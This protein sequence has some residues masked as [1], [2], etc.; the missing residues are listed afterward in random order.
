MQRTRETASEL[1]QRRL[2]CEARLRFRAS[3]EPASTLFSAQT[4]KPASSAQFDTITSCNFRTPVLRFAAGGTKSVGGSAAA[5]SAVIA[6]DGNSRSRSFVHVHEIALG[7][8]SAV[9]DGGAHQ[10]GLLLDRGGRPEPGRILDPDPG[11]PLFPRCQEQRFWV[12]RNTRRLRS[13]ARSLRALRDVGVD[14]PSDDE[15][16]QS[17]ER[18]RPGPRRHSVALGT[19]AEQRADR[20]G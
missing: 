14:T 7:R 6:S 13:W 12:T 17:L 18:V 15:V 1:P 20:Q 8:R 4:E 3:S 9:R 10:H 2:I 5:C 19:A 16:M 11:Q